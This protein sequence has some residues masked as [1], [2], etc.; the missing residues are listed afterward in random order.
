[1][2]AHLLNSN[3]FEK[4]FDF[5]Y[6]PV[7]FSV[8]ATIGYA[9]VNFVSNAAAQ[10]C[11]WKL[12]GFTD[13]ATPCEKSLTVLWSEKDQG[14]AT[15]I[16]RHRNSPIMHSSVKEEFKPALYVDGVRAAFPR[17]TK[18]IKSPRV[19]RY[20]RDVSDAEDVGES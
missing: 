15:I 4:K 3:G 16:D 12:G 9:F 8:M 17:P 10:E 1:M 13:W 14:L 19:Q 7:K 11:F 5:I 2:I 20:S 6:T 18:H